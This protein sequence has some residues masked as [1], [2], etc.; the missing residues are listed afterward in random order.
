MTVRGHGEKFQLGKPNPKWVS[1]LLCL[2]SPERKTGKLL[3]IVSFGR[4]KNQKK[5][6]TLLQA[7]QPSRVVVL[8]L[9]YFWTKLAVLGVVIY[10]IAGQGKFCNVERLNRTRP[11]SSPGGWWEKFISCLGNEEI[12]A[13]KKC[14][15]CGHVRGAWN[16]AA[17]KTL[18]VVSLQRPHAAWE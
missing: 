11:F 3:F 9:F 14:C 2:A 5:K 16:D 12:S 15:G 7:K 8:F 13:K 18:P 6:Q 10:E 4:K 1:S 17:P